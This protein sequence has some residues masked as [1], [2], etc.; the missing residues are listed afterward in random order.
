MLGQ[1]RREAVMT[2]SG[3]GRPT[4]VIG[5]LL[6]AIACS[7]PGALGAQS[8]H[9]LE[10]AKPAD[11]G[12]SPVLLETGIQLF[13][14]A[15]A[16]GELAGA[17]LLVAKEGKVVLHEA[18]G[19]KNARER[20]PMERNTMFR[21]ASNTKPTV[22]TA[23]A[24]LV[25]RGKLEYDAPVSRYIPS[26]DND[27][28]RSI[29]VRHLLSH[30]SDLRIDGLFIEPL[31]ERSPAHPDAPS[32]QLEVARFGDVGAELVPG[33]AYRYN[34]AGFNTLGAL[35]EI[36]SGRTLEGFLKE[37]IFERL[38]M[39]DSYNQEV[40]EKLDGKLSRMS[41]IHSR[42]ADGEWRLT[43]TPGEPPR[44]PFV[45]GSGGMVSTAWDYAHFL[46]MFLNGGSYG[47]VR[48]V[49]SETVEL[50]TTPKSPAIVPLPP[51]SAG[52]D[53]YYGYGWFVREDGIYSHYG[54]DGTLGWVDPKRGI[55]GVVLTGTPGGEN[56]RELFMD[57]VAHAAMRGERDQRPRRA[58]P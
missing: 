32:L 18:V 14:D 51:G 5:T 35:V 25:E 17:V 2:V 26:F 44:V 58:G 19:V 1:Q 54:S 45:R 47:G 52:R 24:M 49:E 12:M 38:G 16:R 39:V 6:L 56:P 40:A 23:I 53:A 28:A 36:A 3:L 46:Q 50:M 20:L 43:W 31:M 27:R 21:M 30:T 9:T 33:E 13:R 34:N 37:E 57:V 29:Q 55:V 11:A 41:A 10:Y 7:A 22:A 15:V 42:N 48:F 8:P 4:R